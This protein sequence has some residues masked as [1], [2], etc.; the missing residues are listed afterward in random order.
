MGGILEVGS[1][2]LVSIPTVDYSFRTTPSSWAVDCGT[3][4]AHG[5]ALGESS[6]LNVMIYF[7]PNRGAFDLWADTTGEEIVL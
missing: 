3:H 1:D 7:R 5:K 4:F 6:A 2:P